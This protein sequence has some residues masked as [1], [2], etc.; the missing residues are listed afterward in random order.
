MFHFF[1]LQQNCNNFFSVWFKLPDDTWFPMV[2]QL[3]FKI[4][5]YY[6]KVINGE[7]AIPPGKCEEC[8]KRRP[9]VVITDCHHVYLCHECMTGD[10]N[11]KCQKCGKKGINYEKL[12]LDPF[13]N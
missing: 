10:K 13:I 7:L 4:N 12:Y 11:K 2:K 3:K 8:K 1:F 6:F 9:D 5:E